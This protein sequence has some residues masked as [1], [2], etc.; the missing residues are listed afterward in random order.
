MAKNFDSEY[1]IQQ[2]ILT[3]V[4][5]D[6]SKNFDSQYSILLE[7]L[8]KIEGGGG[9]GASIDD[10]VIAL[11]KTWSSSKINSELGTKQGTLTAGANISINA[12]GVIS[13]VDTTYTAGSNISIV[14]GEISATDTT[15]SDATQSVAGLMSATDKTKLDGL[16]NYVLPTASANDLGGIKVGSGLSIDANG[17][18][19][20]QGGASEIDDS[21]T[22]LNKTWSSNKINYEL[23]SKQGTLTAGANIAIDVNGVISATDTTYSDATQSA[24]GLMSST[25]KTKLDGIASG[26]Q[27]NVIESISV[28]GNSASISSKAA[29]VTIPNATQSAAGLMSSTDKTKLDGLSNYSLPTASASTLGGIKVGA[30]LSIDANGVLSAQGGTS[31]AQIDDTQASTTTVYSSSKCVST[32]AAKEDL[33]DVELVISEAINDLEANKQNILTAGANIQISASGVISATD[34]T[35]SDATQSTA[36]LMSATDKT[37]LDGLSNYTLPTASA[38]D[39]GG[40]KVGSGLAIDASGVLSVSGMIQID[41][42]SASVSTVYSSSKCESTFAKVVTLTQAQYDAIVTKD[43][44]TI[45]IISDAQ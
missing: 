4:G 31:G 19:S 22:A 44:M 34:T 32:F 24:A 35:Y 28:N 29:T 11:N 15:Y 41:D 43:S 9:G 26:A 7:I 14:N 16:N 40:I 6:G 42:T 23:G 8:D 37:K 12:G 18:L 33:E 1:Q 39:L 3:K 2:S 25:D 21:I 38:N 17:V 27:V 13:A 10:N 36:G 45:Y 5:G 20:A 30:N